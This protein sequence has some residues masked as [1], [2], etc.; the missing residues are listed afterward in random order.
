[1]NSTVFKATPGGRRRQLADEAKALMIPHCGFDYTQSWRKGRKEVAVCFRTAHPTLNLSDIFVFGRRRSVADGFKTHAKRQHDWAGLPAPAAPPD[2]DVACVFSPDQ[3]QVTLISRFHTPLPSC[4]PF[5][6]PPPHLRCDVTKPRDMLIT[7]RCLCGV[8]W[9][10][11][12]LCQGSRAKVVVGIPDE[13]VLQDLLHMPASEHCK[14]F[15]WPYK[16]TK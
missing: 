13:C 7:G 3:R 6:P 12:Q 15:V 10:I 9:P 8:C 16:Q 2:S 14:H 5:P 4:T 1:M 11:S